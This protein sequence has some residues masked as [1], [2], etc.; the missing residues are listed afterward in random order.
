MSVN[1]SQGNKRQGN[2]RLVGMAAAIA[3]AAGAFAAPAV[4]APAER[5]GSHDATRKAVN[6]AVKDG[7]PGVALQAKDRHGV[8]KATAG[9]GNL[10][11]KQPR[12]A[13]DNFRAGSITKTFIATVL[14]QLEA[15]GRVSLD[16]TVDKWLPGVVRGHG[17]DGRKITLRQLLNHTSGIFN[18]TEDESLQSAIFLP[19]GFFKNRYRTWT[20]NEIVKIAM[21]HKPEFAPG[22]SWSY[23]NTNYTLAGMVIKKVTGNSYGDEVRR[24]VIKPL[25]LHGTYMPGTNATVPQPSSRAY[26]QLG[27]NTTGKIYDVTELNPSV[28]NSAG[29]IISNSGDLNRFYSALLRGKVLP[30]KQL[31]EMKT[32]VAAGAVD[33]R[34][35]LGL[36][37]NE[38]SCGVTV[39]GHS[40]G[41]HGSSSVAV[42]TADGKHSL[43]FNFNGD[44]SGD[45]VKVVEAEYC[46]TEK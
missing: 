26:S 7:V 40:G 16:D 10:R 20:P 45:P 18:Y 28:A 24:R 15:E 19:E 46:G 36:I 3:V 39:W 41:I 4:A 35:G 8:W 31:A 27:E 22:A 38:L 42:T 5:G 1:K 13:H 30:A 21:G 23:S 6:A 11:T 32:T 25:G 44:W 43:A 9:L 29:E 17:H 34:Y 14:L 12:S 37:E 33:G 2:K